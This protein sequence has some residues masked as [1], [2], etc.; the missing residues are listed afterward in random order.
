MIF[1]NKEICHKH[2]LKIDKLLIDG[3]IVAYFVREL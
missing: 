3:L 2:R 1:V